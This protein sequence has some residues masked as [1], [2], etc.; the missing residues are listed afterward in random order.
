MSGQAIGTSGEMLSGVPTGGAKPRT[1]DR[2][3][4][5]TSTIEVGDLFLILGTHGIEGQLQRFAGVSR[6]SPKVTAKTSTAP[7]HATTHERCGGTI[8]CNASA[9]A[10][11]MPP[12]MQAAPGSAPKPAVR[13]KY[14][15]PCCGRRVPA[16]AVEIPHV[17]DG[18]TR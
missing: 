9:T 11:A 5:T 15:G 12:P 7:Q 14:T 3:I 4:M 16:P 1:R 10:V 6:V 8:P 13:T 18:E 17:Q 2:N